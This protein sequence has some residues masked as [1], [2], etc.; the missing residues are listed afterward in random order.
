MASVGGVMT[1]M[2]KMTNTAFTPELL[3]YVYLLAAI[4]IVYFSSSG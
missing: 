2:T 4:L 1:K 3:Y